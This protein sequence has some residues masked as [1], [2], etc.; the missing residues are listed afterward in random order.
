MPDTMKTSSASHWTSFA[1]GTLAWVA[2]NWGEAATLV[3]LVKAHADQRGT[4]GA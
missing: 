4:R 1:T 3:P 2:T